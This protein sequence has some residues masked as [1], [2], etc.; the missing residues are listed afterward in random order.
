MGADL[1][2]TVAVCCNKLPQ[3]LSEETGEGNEKP[4]VKHQSADKI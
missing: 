1:Q 4:D 2:V 3:N